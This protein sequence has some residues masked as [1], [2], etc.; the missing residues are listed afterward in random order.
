MGKC[1]APLQLLLNK[2]NL[3]EFNKFP[4]VIFFLK[5]ILSRAIPDAIYNTAL[6]AIWIIYDGV[7]VNAAIKA[8][9]EYPPA[10]AIP[11]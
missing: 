11:S 1:P 7:C 8:A 3:R 4:Q 10:I 2:Q 5:S 6:A 9:A